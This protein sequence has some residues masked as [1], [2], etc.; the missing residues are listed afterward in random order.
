MNIYI[1]IYRY[2]YIYTYIHFF[3]VSII[4]S[5]CFWCISA[6]IVASRPNH[7][8]LVFVCPP[9]Q[10]ILSAVR[11]SDVPSCWPIPP[12]IT[13][14]L[15]LQAVDT[16][17]SVRVGLTVWNLNWLSTSSCVHALVPLGK[18]MDDGCLALNRCN[19]AARSKLNQ[20]SATQTLDAKKRL[21]RMDAGERLRHGQDVSWNRLRV[22]QLRMPD[23]WHFSFAVMKLKWGRKMPWCRKDIELTPLSDPVHFQSKQIVVEFIRFVVTCRDGYHEANKDRCREREGRLRQAVPCLN[24]ISGCTYSSSVR[25]SWLWKWQS[26][27]NQVKM[28]MAQRLLKVWNPQNHPK[29]SSFQ[30]SCHMSS[31]T[32]PLSHCRRA[33]IASPRTQHIMDIPHA[34]WPERCPWCPFSVAWI[35]WTDQSIQ[36]QPWDNFF[37]RKGEKMH[38]PLHLELGTVQTCANEARSFGLEHLLL[39]NWFMQALRLSK[40]DEAAQDKCIHRQRLF[41]QFCVNRC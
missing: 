34:V 15:C 39:W 7:S 18:F 9:A 25:P 13:W 5:S 32:V 36:S 8:N 20:Q 14:E 3:F 4:Y 16:R 2:M 38:D 35:R 33:K 11:A 31:A 12:E 10:S 19:F 40:F 24:G 17:R 41:L 37:W 1:Y 30:F 27:R 28:R 23:L 22:V 29:M 6:F 21:H 26:F